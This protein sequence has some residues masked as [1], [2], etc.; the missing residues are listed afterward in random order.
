M[1]RI[2]TNETIFVKKYMVSLT[3]EHFTV[4]QAVQPRKKT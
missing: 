2:S 1:V 3:K 4:S